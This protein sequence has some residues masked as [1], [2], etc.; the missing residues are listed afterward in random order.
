MV[1]LSVLMVVMMTV[2]ALAVLVVV[3]M[4]M[5]VTALTVLVIM[6]MMM[7]VAAFAVLV[8][9]MMTVAALAVLVVMVVMMLMFLVRNDVLVL[10][11]L[12]GVLVLGL[13]CREYLLAV[14]LIPARGNDRG[15]LVQLTYHRDRL[16]EL[17]LGE[18]LSARPNDR[19]RC[20][21]LIFVELTEILHIHT[22]LGR[23]GDRRVA[24]ERDLVAVNAH[25]RLNNV[26]EL[27]DARRLDEYSV[28]SVFVE[29]LFERLAEIADQGAADAPLVHFGDLDPRV[30]HKAAVNT[31]LAEL[32]FDEHELFP[33]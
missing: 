32:V 19:F 2:T 22:D 1:M 15:V 17:L 18:L 9:V 4:M 6:V 30:L 14:D 28:G 12:L 21:H 5:T 23:V 33:L 13:H 27:A 8:V 20:F 7:T 24:V 29:H 25:Y 10:Q 11:Q 26:G 31:D 16:G 3:I